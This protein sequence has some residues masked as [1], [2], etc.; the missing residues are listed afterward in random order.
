MPNANRFSPLPYLLVAYFAWNLI[1]P[2]CVLAQIDAD[3]E[4][5]RD[6][7]PQ[8]EAV[9]PE[10]V[11]DPTVDYA[12]VEPNFPAPPIPH[13]DLW[14]GY[15]DGED[16]CEPCYCGEAAWAYADVLWLRRTE[17]DSRVLATDQN[18]GGAVV[19]DTANFDFSFEPG[20]RV[21]YGR[22]IG[23]TPVEVSYFGTH[24]WR[25]GQIYNGLGDSLNSPIAAALLSAFTDADSMSTGYSA[26]LH[27]VE[28]N[29]FHE[30]TCN[31]A[32]LAGVRYVNV[33]E[34][35]FLVSFDGLNI[36]QYGIGADNHL[37]G[38]QLGAQGQHH[39]GRWRFDW[40]LKGGI[41]ANNVES[42]TSLFDPAVPNVFALNQDNTRASFIGEAGLGLAVEICWGMKIRGGYQV[43]WIDGAALAVDQV[44]QAPLVNAAAVP[45]LND[46]SSIVLDGGYLG[47]E[48]CR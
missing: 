29:F 14:A 48:W 18:L 36:G 46:S 20:F 31:V 16:W 11:D 41:Y 25:S 38:G 22:V 43:T 3:L 28:L 30:K 13:A 1:S 27:N 32:V 6:P 5:L 37:I 39:Q 21:G 8:M 24:N 26:D 35:F 23:A 10:I 47:L 7:A 44:A 4:L 42:T 33:N 45:V 12:L 15:C 2:P 17:G 19:L 40:M 34:D 9:V